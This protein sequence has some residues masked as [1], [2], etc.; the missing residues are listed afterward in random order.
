MEVHFSECDE[1]NRSHTGGR[2]RLVRWTGEESSKQVQSLKVAKAGKSVIALKRAWKRL[3]G[4]YGSP[5]KVGSGS[6]EET[7]LCPLDDS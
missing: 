2:T 1:G 3:D 4:R 7:E 6:Q 5:V